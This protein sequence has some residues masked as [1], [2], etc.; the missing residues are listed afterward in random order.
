QEEFGY[1]PE[2]AVNWFSKKLGIPASNFFGVAT[3]YSQ[4]HLK[5]R[6]RKIITACCGTACYVK[7]AERLMSSAVRELNLSGEQ[8]TTDDGEITLEKVACLGTCSMAPVVVINKKMHGQMTPEK[9]KKE[10]KAIRK[11]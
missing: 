9:L 1:I 4:F 2:D 7:G 3:F 11:K 8:E 5:P 10:I 6:G